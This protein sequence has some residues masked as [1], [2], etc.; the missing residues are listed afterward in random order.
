MGNIL[1]PCTIVKSSD[2]KIKIQ[3]FVCQCQEANPLSSWT[4]KWS[5]NTR[6]F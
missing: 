2:L 6:P 3:S 5:R 4:R 1:I